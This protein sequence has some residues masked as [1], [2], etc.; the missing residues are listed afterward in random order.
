MTLLLLFQKRDSSL[1]L[2]TGPAIPVLLFPCHREEHERHGD[3]GGEALKLPRGVYPERE[4]LP[5]H[6]VQGQNG[7]E[8][9]TRS[10]IRYQ[11]SLTPSR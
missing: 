8:Q 10:D 7:K 9:R 3:L 11:H 2:G 4:I 5:L 6:F 1:V